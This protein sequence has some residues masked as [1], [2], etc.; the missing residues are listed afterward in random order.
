M[1]DEAEVNDIDGNLGIETGLEFIP[2]NFLN[3]LR[4][5]GRSGASGS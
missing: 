1:I 5:F 2:D 4:S 3:F